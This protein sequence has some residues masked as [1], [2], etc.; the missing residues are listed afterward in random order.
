MLASL[1]YFGHAFNP[2]TFYFCFRPGGETLDAVIAEVT[3]TPWG[4]RHAYT[5]A[6]DG[7]PVVSGALEK[8]FH[9]SPLMG[10]DHE[11][12]LRVGDP[13]ETPRACTS[14]PTRDG[15]RAFDATLSLGAASSGRAPS[16]ACCCA[17]PAMTM[18]V[19]AAI[20]FEAAR[21][22]LKGARYHPHPGGRPHD[23]IRA[24][25]RIALALAARVRGGAPR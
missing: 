20:Y 18:R 8:A 17:I 13:G 23:A 10:M 3:N 19:L 5:V 4:E 2:V 7:G 1:R 6:A 16:T 14:P 12:D 25:R 15:E 24:A 21:L 9:V 11:Y 22:R